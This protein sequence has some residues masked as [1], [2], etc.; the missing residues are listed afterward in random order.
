MPGCST[1]SNPVFPSLDSKAS[2][3]YPPMGPMDSEPQ[4]FR[5]FVDTL[6]DASRAYTEDFFFILSPSKSQERRNG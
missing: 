4:H 6:L 3:G 2:D 5:F 1:S